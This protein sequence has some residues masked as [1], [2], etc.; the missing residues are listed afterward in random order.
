MRKIL[1]ILA[2]IFL[3]NL[4]AFA[5]VTTVPAQP[6]DADSVT[7][8]FNATGTPLANYA[9]DIYAHAGLI[10]SNSSSNSDWKYVPMTW[11]QN[12]PAFKLIKTGTNTY[13]LKYKPSIRTFFSS[14]Y[15]SPIPSSEQILKMAFVFRSAVLVSGAYIQTSPDILVPVYG[16]QFTITN[17]TTT[18][19][20]S[21]G[22]AIPV[23]GQASQADSIVLFV[24]NV[25][26][27]KTTAPILQYSVS[28][29]GTGLHWIKG[30]AYSGTKKLS[31]SVAYF[32]KKQTVVAA[33]P[34]GVK[35]GIN[36]IDNNTVT[37]S[38]FAPQKNNVIV[39]G[40]FNNWTMSN[41]YVMN[42]TPDGTRYWL[43]LTNLTPQKEYIFQYLV[44][45][46]IRI[47]DPYCEKVSDPWN[48]SYIPTT[49]YPNLISYPNGKTTGI[50]SVL[51][52]GQTPYTWKTTNFVAPD[53]SNLT[54]YELLIRDFV[55]THSIKTVKD[56]LNYL[57]NL[58][59]NAIE[60][61]PFSEFEG[62]D[63]WGYNP[64]Y[65]FAP[66]K[67]YGV[68]NDYKDFIDECHRR[69]IAVIMDMVFNQAFGT[70]PMVML[71]WN[72]AASQPAANN[73]WFNQIATHPYSVGYDFNHESIYTKNYVIRT[74]RYWMTEYNIDGFR[75]DLS[76]GFTQFNS[77]TDVN[78]WGQY[79]QSR[80][81]IWE[82]YADSIW[83]TKSNAYII[84]EHFADNQEEKFLSSYVNK[85][86][87]PK[88]TGMMLWG[89]MNYAYSQMSEGFTSGSDITDII[90]WASWQA[91]GW[92]KPN[93]VSYMESH[94]EDRMEFR[95]LQYGNSLGSYN[96]QNATTA[97]KRCALAA[98]FFYTIP[99]PKMLW[100]FGELGYDVSIDSIGRLA[101]KPIRWN[102]Y[103]SYNRRRLYQVDSALI[104][105]RNKYDVFKTTDYN[106]TI[107]D[108]VRSI[109]LNNA[110]MNVVVLGNMDVKTHVI[111]PQFQTNGTWYEYY[112]NSSL[113]VAD[114]NALITLQPGEYRLYTSAKVQTP[115]VLYS[116]NK[117]DN[118]NNSS[119]S[120]FP[121]PFFND[122]KISF[123]SSG[124]KN[125]I[126]S[127]SDIYGKIIKMQQINLAGD[128]FNEYTWDGAGSNGKKV[129]SGVYFY[130]IQINGNS[131]TGKIL[132][133]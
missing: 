49:V 117:I 78:L 83:S 89:N 53:K 50:A 35:D 97:L 113:N 104:S 100:Q 4:A 67:Y 11:G 47:G 24:D 68:K 107:T 124:N 128:G 111:S 7:I 56:S 36:Y 69:G 70:C 33:L 119:A 8:N 77:G 76:K 1:F 42:Q 92:H 85:Y 64:N 39:L 30:T 48:D 23:T 72:S 131:L 125:A 79:D 54:I 59:V 16:F 25:R 114:V 106:I 18:T 3:F 37:L 45:G 40:D 109:H 122:T 112:T 62:N 115:F 102:Y 32:I 60:L 28:A 65:Y 82:T 13:Y 15:A 81:N 121:N 86:K 31:D 10:T 9:G 96:I 5:Q 110:N 80:V 130:K 52:T 118:N 21:A 103:S 63:S 123:I 129:S 12:L 20:V 105:L 108:T 43:T 120:V 94:D 41:D 14:F 44:D 58:G 84:L 46:T 34:A 93:L 91:R 66:D 19:I 126:I 101:D 17:P 87:Q 127:I 55:A 116:V 26:L 75:F 6:T 132:K 51:Q 29:S 2:V 133:F 22:Q 88:D 90:S 99:G 95:N 57:Q 71:Y 27:Y 61:M 74:C 98:N 73:P 38:L